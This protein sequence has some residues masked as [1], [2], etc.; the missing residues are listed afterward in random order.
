MT[1]PT[2]GALTQLGSLCCILRV[3]DVCKMRHRFADQ[4]VESLFKSF[5]NQRLNSHESEASYIA[6]YGYSLT[7]PSI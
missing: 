7:C 5:Y 4:F 2:E 1:N 6:E 3:I